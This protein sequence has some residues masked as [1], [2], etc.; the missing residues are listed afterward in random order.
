MAVFTVKNYHGVAECASMAV[1]VDRLDSG[2]S[3]ARSHRAALIALTLVFLAGVLFI[4][5]AALPYFSLDQ[6]QFKGYWPR[7]WWLLAH[8]TMGIV[9]LLS[10]PVPRSQ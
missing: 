1:T 4:V 5:Q 9:A 7:R 8:L 2:S 6:T 10:G 3:T